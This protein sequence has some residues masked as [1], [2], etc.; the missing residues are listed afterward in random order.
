M[1]K[2][3]KFSFGCVRGQNSELRLML[4]VVSVCYVC[5]I[6]QEHILTNFDINIILMK[7]TWIFLYIHNLTINTGD[8]YRRQLC[9]TSPHWKIVFSFR[10]LRKVLYTGHSKTCFTLVTALCWIEVFV[11]PSCEMLWLNLASSLYLMT[12]CEGTQSGLIEA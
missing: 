7:L 9:S 2:K 8:K 4:Y 1:K 5:W 11:E 6:P 10:I 12:S 3:T